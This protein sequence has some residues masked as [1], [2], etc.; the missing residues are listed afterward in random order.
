MNNEGA[1][2]GG[3][4]GRGAWDGGWWGLELQVPSWD[5]VMTS[6]CVNK[7][8]TMKQFMPEESDSEMHRRKK[9][10]L[11]GKLSQHMA[12]AMQ[13]AV[14]GNASS[15]AKGQCNTWHLDICTPTI[16]R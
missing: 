2:E 4:G 6:T 11:P 3:E 12:L 15:N 8:L 13:G 1:G 14:P 9:K 7:C 16:R 10:R 5:Q